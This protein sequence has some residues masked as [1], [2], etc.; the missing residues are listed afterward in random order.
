MGMRVGYFDDLDKNLGLGFRVWDRVLGL[1]LGIGIRD[2]KLESNIGI[3]EGNG[4]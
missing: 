3:W 1:G 4:I 2:W